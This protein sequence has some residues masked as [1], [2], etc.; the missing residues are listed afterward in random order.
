MHSG[1]PEDLLLAVL[2]VVAQFEANLIFFICH[3]HVDTLIEDEIDQDGKDCVI[4]PL[5]GVEYVI[6]IAFS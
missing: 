3:P 4:R 1:P 2:V 5:D 6:V